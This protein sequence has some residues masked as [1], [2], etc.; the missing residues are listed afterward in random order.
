MNK[1]KGIASACKILPG[2]KRACN[3]QAAEGRAG[4][5]KSQQARPLQLK[6]IPYSRHCD[7]LM[8]LYWPG[9]FDGDHLRPLVPGIREQLLN[10]VLHFK[11][12]LSVRQINRCL[13]KLMRC[14]A[15]LLSI[16]TGTFR[17]DVRGNPRMMIGEKEEMTALARLARMKHKQTDRTICHPR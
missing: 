2:K 4:K 14:E 9:I 5:E 17:Y 15:Y 10:D 12:P 1:T 13:K 11:L 6:N 16:R 7:E 8:K 3:A